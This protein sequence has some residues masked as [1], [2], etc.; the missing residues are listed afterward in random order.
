MKEKTPVTDDTTAHNSLDLVSSNSSKT[1]AEKPY[2]GGATAAAADLEKGPDPAAKTGPPAAAGPPGAAD[3]PEGGAEAWLV[4]AG[5]WTALFCTFGLVNCIGVFEQYY[6]SV[7]L[8]GYSSSTVSWI[9]SVQVFVMIFCGTIVGDFPPSPTPWVL[10]FAKA[11]ICSSSLAA[12]LTTMARG[13]FSGAAPS[14]TS[15][16]S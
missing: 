10:I 15:S 7:P 1:D 14:S 5:G 8:R 4:V 9:P 3:F 6:V 12:S 13:C 16:A 2:A 11:D